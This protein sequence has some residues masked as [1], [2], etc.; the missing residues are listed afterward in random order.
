M[1]AVMTKKGFENA[2][3][4]RLTEQ[5]LAED[6]IRR[7]VEFYGKMIA[8][9]MEDGMSEEE[10]VAALGEMDAIVREILM[11][12]PLATLVKQKVKPK[13]SLSGGE[14]AFLIVLA[15][16]G[17]PIWLSLA[18]A[19]LAVIIAVYATLFA[20]IV[21]TAAVVFSLFVAGVALLPV[22][23]FFVSPT[24]AGIVAALGAGFLLIGMGILFIFPV[25]YTVWGLM[26]LVML[27][28]RGI[29]ALFIGKRKG[30]EDKI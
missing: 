23:C 4:T 30:T 26:K 6:E 14:T 11:D 16:L 19:A 9:R 1:E 24:A 27:I 3:R 2:L 15:V 21:A 20:L 22:V 10:A 17:S 12:V 18:V 7:S 28:P 8:D 13:R 5:G 29:K 25:K